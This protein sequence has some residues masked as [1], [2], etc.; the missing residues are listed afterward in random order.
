MKGLVAKRQIGHEER[1]EMNNV[2]EIDVSKGKS[3]LNA[4]SKSLEQLKP[5]SRTL[6]QLLPEYPVVVV[7]RG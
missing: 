1:D 6:A 3:A 7:M 5:E 4:G 2:A